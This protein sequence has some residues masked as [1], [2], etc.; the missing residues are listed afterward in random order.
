MSKLQLKGVLPPMVTPFKENGDVDYDSFIYNIRSWNES[1]LTGYLVL[2]SNSETAYLSHE[3]KIKLI[4]LTIEN[5][6]SHK[7]VMVGSG[8]ESIR[9]T[10]KLTNRAAM[11]GANSAILLTPF[12]YCGK[13]DTLAL[14]NYFTTVSDNTDIPVLI[15][16]VPKFTHVNIGADALAKLSEH[17][18]IIGIKD[19]SGDVP[20]LATFKQISAN[21]FNVMVGTAS[22]WYPALALGIKAGVHALANCCPNEC[23]EVQEA[24]EEGNWEEARNIYLRMLPVNAAVTDRFGIAGLKYAC[25]LL[26][27][28]GGYV[29]SPLQQLSDSQKEGLKEIL[30]TAK[31]LKSEK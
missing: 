11:L 27:F 20:Q 21:D 28:K 2:G 1:K 9:E 14:V 13:M 5:A 15:Y 17:P 4:E 19:S 3:E 16:N 24:F 23:A 12:L 31:V 30:K 25:D 8:L 6:A 7:H 22:A 26:G 10:I 18:N 29:R